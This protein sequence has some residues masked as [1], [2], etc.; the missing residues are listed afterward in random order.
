MKKRRISRILNAVVVVMSLIL[1]FLSIY[2]RKSF[3][4]VSFEQLLYSLTTSTGA[5]FSAIKEGIIFVGIGLLIGCFL[6]KLFYWLLKRVK[7]S[8]VFFIKIGKKELKFVIDSF[9]VRF[10]S[11]ILFVIAVLF[12]G[13]YLGVF[14]YINQQLNR[15]TIFE[16]YY[17]DASRVEFK[18]P[19]EKKN[20]IYIIV[21]SLEGT[22]MSEENGGTL[23]ESYIPNLEMFASDNIS[24]SNSDKLGG[25]YTQDGNSWTAGALISH[26]A[27]IP[28]KVSVDGNSYSG[29]GSVLPGNYSIGEVLE[30]NGYK[31]YFL[32]GSD[33]NFG[34]RKE[35]FEGHG[36]YR[37]MDYFWAKEEEKIPDDYYVWWGYEDV[38][39]YEFAKQEL[40]EISQNDDPFNFTMLTADTHFFDG[41]IGDN[42]PNE[43]ENQYANSFYCTDMM[44]NDFINWI[45]EQEFYKDTVVVI[46]GD[47]LTMQQ[48]FFNDIGSYERVVYNTFIN[49]GISEVNNKNRIVSTMDMYPTT[50]A[51]LG[52]EI[53]GD[54]L[55]LGTNLFSNKKTLL[56]ELGSDFVNEELLKRSNF[57]NNELLKD[58]YY[59]ME[60]EVKESE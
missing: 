35:Y 40:L 41:Y 60:K 42:C 53:P 27:G 2:I 33:A 57:Y 17:V 28:L 43:F 7:Y 13:S 29:Y 54:R 19:D 5:S 49:T 55:G 37:I 15:S 4:D 36:N 12:S 1:I 45:K 25:F 14:E 24:F 18:F 16:D 59:E 32:L 26:T 44:I 9:L 56:E 6:L 38:K 21:E 52:V 8:I 34:G 58:A 47:H 20:L 11:M 23:E 22:L 30:D 46:V 3:G 31:N 50:L 39:L 51:A 48:D 10:L